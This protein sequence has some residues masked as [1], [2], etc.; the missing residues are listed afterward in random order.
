[1]SR[2]NI[3]LPQ[4]TLRVLQRVVPK[5]ERSRLIN[6]AIKFYLKQLGRVRLEK[7][8]EEGASRRAG[9]DLEITRDWFALE[10][11]IWP[12]R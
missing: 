2:V 9:R 12:K 10:N 5:G 8:L 11:E 6:Q 3:T 1:M 7:K 4:D